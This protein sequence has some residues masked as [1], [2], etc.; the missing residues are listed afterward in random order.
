MTIY[1]VYA[2]LRK[3]GTPYYI[4]KGK[5]NRVYEKHSVTIPR[6]RSRIVFCEKN[7]TEIGA[8]AIER[9]LIRWW[10]RKDLGTGILN[11]RT[12]GGDGS[13]GSIMSEERRA[14]ISAAIKKKYDDPDYVSKR[15]AASEKISATVKKIWEDPEYRTKITAVKLGVKRG[16]QS[17]EQRAKLSA[18]VKKR[19]E[20]PEQRAKL[21]AAFRLREEKKRRKKE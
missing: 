6:E 15:V 10:G 9:R 17:P 12:D 16:K 1:Y 19:W 8:L 7:L 5:G 2:Y 18:V 20:D 21:S 3:N 11:N 14:K 13:S 4:G